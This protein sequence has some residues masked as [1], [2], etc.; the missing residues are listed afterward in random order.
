V[1]PVLSEV[2]N[3]TH[4][5]VKEA[6]R[7]AMDRITSVVSSPEIRALAPTLL[8][9]LSQTTEQSTKL[10]LDALLNAK[11]THNV[12]A[13]SLAMVCPIVLRALKAR[14]AEMKRKGA[15]IV[16]SM[17]LLIREPADI[18]PHLPVLMPALK[19][20]LTDPIPDVRATSAKAFG[21]I[22]QGLPEDLLGDLVRDC[23]YW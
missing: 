12:D 17:V 9:S 1:V 7:A 20:A 5:K 21:T 14:S 19:L 2:V 23:F 15:Q 8:K 4:A 3:D 10:V 6:A 22:A 13:P 16:G 18:Q 11:F